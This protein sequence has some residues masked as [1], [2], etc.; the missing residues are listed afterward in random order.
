MSTM[1]QIIAP[2]PAGETVAHPESL[3]MVS[4]G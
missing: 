4:A 1:D 3:L 2:Y